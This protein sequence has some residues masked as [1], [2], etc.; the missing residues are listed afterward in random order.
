M[1]FLCAGCESQPSE[2]KGGRP[3]SSQHPRSAWGMMGGQRKALAKVPSA[4]PTR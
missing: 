2:L 4:F 3:R 1:G